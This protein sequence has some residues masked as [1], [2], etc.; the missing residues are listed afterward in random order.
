VKAHLVRC[1]TSGWVFAGL[2][3]LYQK[4]YRLIESYYSRLF[5]LQKLGASYFAKAVSRCAL[6]ACQE[7][8]QSAL[9]IVIQD[10][11]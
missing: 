4:R 1:G 10:V 11:F 6:N 3:Y 8:G 7:W 5:G 9:I 2:Y